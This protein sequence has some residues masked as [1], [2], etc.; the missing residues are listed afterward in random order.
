M[1]LTCYRARPDITAVVHTHPT[2]TIAL[3]SAGYGVEPVY[4]DLAALVG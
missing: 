2:M 3:V 1:H 4:P